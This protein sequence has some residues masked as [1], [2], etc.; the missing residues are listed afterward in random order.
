MIQETGWM[1]CF[2][3]YAYEDSGKDLSA[4][5]NEGLEKS[6]QENRIDWKAHNEKVLERLLSKS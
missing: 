6:L 1:G 5:S 3:F 2:P 4:P